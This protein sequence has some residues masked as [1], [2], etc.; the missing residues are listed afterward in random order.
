[1][2]IDRS[3]LT[4]IVP[5]IFQKNEKTFYIECSINKTLH[6]CAKARLD[7][8]IKK[9]GSLEAVGTSY[10]S[11]AA[12]SSNTT[13]K[14][15]KEPKQKEKTAVGAL[16]TKPNEYRSSTDVDDKVYEYASGGTKCLRGAL[17]VQNNGYCNGCQWWMKCTY[18]DKAW[19]NTTE[20]PARNEAMFN[21]KAHK[22]DIIPEMPMPGTIER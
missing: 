12:K 18:P 19:A 14:E 20:S 1:M 21:L 22:M 15:P 17:F 9:H 8:L 5:G 11:R 10:I 2:D 3:K 7:K 4:E 6:Y 13:K 16:L